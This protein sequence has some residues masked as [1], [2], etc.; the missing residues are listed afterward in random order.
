[1][2]WSKFSVIVSHALSPAGLRV[3]RTIYFGNSLRALVLA[4]PANNA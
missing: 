2:P 3:A 4:I 1:M